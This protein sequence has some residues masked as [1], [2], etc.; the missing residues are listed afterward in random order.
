MA[1]GGQGV[2]G[3]AGLGDGDDQLLRVGDRGAVAVFAGDL[4]GARDA[5]D[6]FEP[7]AGGVAGVAAGAAGE[8]QD[9]IDVL[10]EVGGCG[11]EDAGLDGLAAADDF[12]GV[13]QR[14][15]LLEDFL[16]HVVLVGAEFDGGGGKLRDMH[17]PFDRGAVEAGDPDAGCGQLGDVA[18][19]Q[20]DHVAGDLEQCRGVGGGVV[21]AVGDG[22]A[23][24]ASLRGRR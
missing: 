2:G 20:I 18:V 6:G 23:A 7:V 15:G 24:A 9:G 4:D 5:G 16:L 1:Q 3:F 21:A 22:R 14:F 19:F 17:R 13:G 11:A 10:Q 12:E 8:D